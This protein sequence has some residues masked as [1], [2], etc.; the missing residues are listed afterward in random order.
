MTIAVYYYPSLSLSL[1]VFAL[2]RRQRSGLQVTVVM[3]VYAK[4]QLSSYQ[5]YLAF[6]SVNETAFVC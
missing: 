1:S 2:V 3:M 6:L 4:A 5:I